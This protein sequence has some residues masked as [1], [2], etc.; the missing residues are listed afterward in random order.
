MLFYCAQKYGNTAA[1]RVIGAVDGAGN[2][3]HKGSTKLDGTLFLRVAGELTNGLGWVAHG[4][5]E[6][7]WDFSGIGWEE[8]WVKDD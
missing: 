1:G 2:E 6:R 5:E 7:F 4:E 8:A 3:T